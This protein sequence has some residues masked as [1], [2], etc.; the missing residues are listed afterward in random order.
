VATPPPPPP[1]P[2][3]PHHLPPTP[4]PSQLAP[5]ARPPVA[6]MRQ[7][8]LR[9]FRAAAAARCSPRRDRRPTR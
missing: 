1:P 2:P 7:S 6:I 3:P 8:L 5:R 9:L 4:T